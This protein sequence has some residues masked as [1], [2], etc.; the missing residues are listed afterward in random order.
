MVLD[1]IRMTR[2]GAYCT[3]LGI[4]AGQI[5]N[6]QNITITN[7]GEQRRDFTYVGDV[8]N[9]NLLSAT[10]HEKLNGEVYNVGNG[11]NASIN[12]LAELFEVKTEFI[13]DRLEPKATLADISKIKYI[14]GWEPTGDVK[15]WVKNFVKELKVSDEEPKSPELEY[16]LW[17]MVSYG[18]G[19]PLIPFSLI[20]RH[21][22]FEVI[23]HQFQEKIKTSPCIITT[24]NNLR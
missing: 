1:L 22:R 5:E 3:V 15:K 14:L 7:D 19:E 13:G 6:G 12:E 18:H 24:K 2:E 23:Y 10:H 9:A 8:V 21:E 17:D 11:D 16:E 20:S 4:W